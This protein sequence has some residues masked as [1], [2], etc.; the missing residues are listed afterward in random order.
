MGEKL[1]I[2]KNALVKNTCIKEK[3]VNRLLIFLLQAHATGMFKAI[4]PREVEILNPYR[5]VTRSTKIAIPV[6]PPDRRPAGLI[7]AW[8]T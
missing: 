7:N 1:N 4:M 6:N 8:I 3:K 5:D 2:L